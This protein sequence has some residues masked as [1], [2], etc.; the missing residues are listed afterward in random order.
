MDR[1]SQSKSDSG[2]TGLTGS[3]GKYRELVVL[4]CSIVAGI[5][6]W[7]NTSD[8][9]VIVATVLALTIVAAVLLWN[10]WRRR[11]NRP[12]ALEPLPTDAAFRG[13]DSY[14]ENDSERF[15]GRG[16]D[17]GDLDRKVRHS[18]FRFGVLMG[19]SGT[20]KTSFHKAGL[21]PRLRE[22]GCLPVYVRLYREP[23]AMIKAAVKKET[24]LSCAD[25][26][27]LIA[28]LRRVAE[29]NEKTLVLCCDQF[30]EFFIR[31][32]AD[33]RTPFLAF[34][35]RCFEDSDLPVKFLFSLRDDFLVR[36]SEFDAYIPEP[37]AIDK[38]YHLQSLDARQAAN[39][40]ERSVQA[41]GV[42]F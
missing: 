13:L 40:I 26:E 7:F 27:E 17:T 18:D 12:K 24:G 14:E 1:E 38:R 4:V 15:Y 23:E 16:I 42:L 22:N 3:I 28:Y 36:I 29:E 20:G 35:G 31:F 6:A 32:P 25:D 30:E 33:E 2:V 39:I 10:Y 21:I 34:V 37:L 11:K 5:V 9:D 19:E 41:A 8:R